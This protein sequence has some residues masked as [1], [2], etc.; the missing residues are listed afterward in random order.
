LVP[1][2]NRVKRFP[3][4]EIDFLH[5]VFALGLITRHPHGGFKKFVEMRQ[6]RQLEIL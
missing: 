3:G 6:G 4:L 5:E 2:S 1:I